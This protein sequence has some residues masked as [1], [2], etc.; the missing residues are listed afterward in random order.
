M[1]R[2]PPQQV[3]LLVE[4]DDSW[5]RGFVQGVADYTET[6]GA[7]TLLIDPRDRQGRL[8]LPEGWAGGRHGHHHRQRSLAGASGDRRHRAGALALGHPL[9]RPKSPYPTEGP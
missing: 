7:W 8:R 9:P 5:G 6:H 1:N 2:H 4:V 3:A